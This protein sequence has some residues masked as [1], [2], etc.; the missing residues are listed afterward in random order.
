MRAH[1][2]GTGAAI[3]VGA[4]AFGLSRVV[5]LDAALLALVLGLLAGAVLR[6]PPPLEP[7]TS[8]VAKRGLEASIVLVG[9]E[10]NLAFLLDAG[11]RV[12]LLVAILVPLTFG[13]FLLMGRT[14]GLRGDAPALL[15]VGTAICGLSAIAAAGSTLKSRQEDVAIAVAAVGVLSAIGLVLYPLLGLAMALPPDVYGAWSGLSL[16]AIANA[17]AAGFAVGPE[18]GRMATLTKLARVALLAPLLIA[19]PLLLRRRRE[20]RL[21]PSALPVT[22]WGFLVVVLVVSF[23]PLPDALLAALKLA[24]RA[25]LVV[26]IA[27]VG[28]GT[29][30]GHFRSAGP[31]TLA[32]ATGGW[33]LLSGLS[34]LLALLLL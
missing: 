9:V 23:L 5:P 32:L 4:A 8:W 16:Q 3:L 11:P 30:L 6:H 25:V 29:R 26:S 20:A 10:V 21:G 1:L 15:G 27:A 31:R 2:L 33:L 34:L 13:V 18:A 19:L 28:Y 7:G 22:V 12:L 14:L 17:V 24:L